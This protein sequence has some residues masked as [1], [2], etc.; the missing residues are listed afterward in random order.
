MRRIASMVSMASRRRSSSPVDE[1][2]REGVEDEVGG[3]EAVALD[4]EVVDAL[5]DPQLPL[6]VAGLALLVDRAGR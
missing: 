4:R 6:G 3:L 5:G 1:R 2:E